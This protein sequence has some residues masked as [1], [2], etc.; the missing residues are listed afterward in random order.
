MSAITISK[1]NIYP[2]FCFRNVLH[3]FVHC[4]C[5]TLLLC[6]SRYSSTVDSKIMHAFETVIIDWTHQV[7]DVLNKDSA[8]PILDKLNP[9]P[10]V[11]FDFWNNRLK[12]LEC[13]HEQVSFVHLSEK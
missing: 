4:T 13:I 2:K 8:Q 12:N 7:A 3:G 11:E 9:L 1:I 10:K 5:P 6:S